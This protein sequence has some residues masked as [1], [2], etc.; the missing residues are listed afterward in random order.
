MLERLDETDWGALHDAYGPAAKTP[1]RIRA[2]AS[3]D[4]AKREKALDRLSYTIYHQ[5]TIY[6][7]SVAAVPFLLE[8]VGSPEVPDRTAALQILQLLSTGTS[9]HEVHGGLFL[10]REQANTSEWQEHIREE[11]SWVEQIHQR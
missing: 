9:Y 7:A 2:L 3:S 1:R 6:S 10:N 8:I 11:K 4:K 5:G